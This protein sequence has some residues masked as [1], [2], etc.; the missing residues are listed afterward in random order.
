MSKEKIIIFDTTLRDGEQ[1]AGATMN[2]SEKLAIAK[3]L[4]QMGVDII[5]A[6]FAIASE[7]DF[8]AVNQIAKLTPIIASVDIILD[9]K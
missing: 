4:D 9:R 8:N 5:E 7:G 1:S 2:L 3:L 6:G